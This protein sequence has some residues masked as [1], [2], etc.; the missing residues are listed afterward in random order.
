[1]AFLTLYFLQAQAFTLAMGFTFHAV[2]KYIA[3]NRI[4]KL[5]L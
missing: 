5:M 1:L 3:D 2:K 4:V